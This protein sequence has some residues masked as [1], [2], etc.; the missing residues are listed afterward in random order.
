VPGSESLRAGVRGVREGAGDK[1][2]GICLFRLPTS[3]DTTTLRLAEIAAALRDREPEFSTSLSAEVV[4]AGEA[5]SKEVDRALTKDSNQLLLAAVNDGAGG[6][7]Y[8]D[9]AVSV[10]LRVPRGSVR[11]VTRLEGFDTFET[12]CETLQGEP[13][14][15]ALRPCSAARASVVRLGARAWRPGARARAGLSFEAEVPARLA[16]LVAVRREDGGMWERLVS[17]E[18]EGAG[19]R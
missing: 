15:A 6:A 19:G 8:G 17:V 10:T 13:A 1:L 11:G 14:R 3:G 16:A 18:I 4:A 5:E 2:L 7:P 9:G 12:L